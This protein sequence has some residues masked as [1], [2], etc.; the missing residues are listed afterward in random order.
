MRKLQYISGGYY[1]VSP[2]S[3]PDYMDKEIVPDT[4]YSASE[5]ICDFHPDINILWGNTKRRKQEYAQKL[6]ISDET[7]TELE[8]WV[9]K[10]SEEDKFTY[11]QVFTSVALTQEF[12][13]EFLSQIEDVKIIG[14]GLPENVVEQFIQ[15]QELSDNEVRDEYGVANLLKNKSPIEVEKSKLLGY[16]ILGYEYGKFHSYLCNGLEKDYKEQFGFSLNEYGFISTLE[17]ASRLCDYSNDE[18]IGTEPVLW[19]PWA[20]FEYK[21]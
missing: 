17:E 16:E 5:C 8:K 3:R 14:V 9:E 12:F 7:Y 19:L 4:V 2:L 15:D 1:I 6:N 11:P 20:I 21:M 18:E 10:M 13:G